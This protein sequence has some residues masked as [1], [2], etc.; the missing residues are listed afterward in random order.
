MSSLLVRSLRTTSIRPSI[1]NQSRL[2]TSTTAAMGVTI[3]RIAP[4]DGKT[5]PK[6]GD[7]VT[8]HY[9]GTLESGS[10]FDSSR[11]RGTPFQTEIGVGRVIRGWDEGVPQLSLGE[12]ATLTITGDYG[13][14]ARGYPPVIPPNAT[15]IVS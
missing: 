10:K 1:F 6:K 15:L 12:K 2:F 14:G 11:D 9:I 7:L 13:Y 5:F 4:G 3:N 8:M